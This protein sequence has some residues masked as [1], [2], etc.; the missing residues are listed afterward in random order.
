MSTE[1]S[2]KKQ[3][4][5]VKRAEFQLFSDLAKQFAAAK[6]FPSY[7][8]EQ[9][10]VLMKAGQEMGMAEME[11]INS[12]YIVNGK[13]EIYGKAMPTILRR[14]GWKISYMDEEERSVIVQVEKYGE[15]IREKVTDQDQII[16]NSKAAKFAKKN[17]MRFHGLRMILNF[18]LP[19]LINGVADLFENEAI[20]YHEAEE[21]KEDVDLDDVAEKLKECKSRVD[22]DR[23][24]RSLADEF[25]MSNDAIELFKQK[26]EEINQ[27]KKDDIE[28]AEVVEETKEVEKSEKAEVKEE[29]TEKTNAL[30]VIK[31][32]LDKLTDS[33]E[34]APLYRKLEN[35]GVDVKAYSRLFSEKFEEL[36]NKNKN[37]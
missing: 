19:H 15:I 6:A 2:I 12:L 18:H 31:K 8:P 26:Q 25:N 34:V 30:E 28:E 16:R 29:N 37:D 22:L 4:I 20:E 32:Q 24:Y 17:K 11:A 27:S 13:V 23:L 10:F 3:Q 36:K 7:T 1:L 5:E 9:L 14:A 33:N 21:V 35:E